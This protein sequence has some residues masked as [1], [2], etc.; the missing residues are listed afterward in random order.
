MAQPRP[1]RPIQQ[2][3]PHGIGLPLRAGYAL[4]PT[5]VPEQTGATNL[6]DSTRHVITAGAGLSL[7]RVAGR[8]LSISLHA[9]AHVLPGRTHTKDLER[10]CA[11]GGLC[12]ADTSK[13]GFQSDNPGYPSLR[14]GGAVLFGGLTL[15]LG[16]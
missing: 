14:G 2:L 15:E 13:A 4:L 11:D 5:P 9:G 12:D 3:I 8:P 7:P 6:L 16:L 10:P 1:D